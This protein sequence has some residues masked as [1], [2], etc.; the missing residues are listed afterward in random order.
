[1][2]AAHENQSQKFI[3]GTKKLS[4]TFMSMFFGVFF[5]AEY[6]NSRGNVINSSFLILLLF[7][8]IPH[9]VRPSV[10]YDSETRKSS[11]S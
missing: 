1:M 7:K 4:G 9:T 5:S 2:E 11:I 8:T 3:M 6:K 10:L